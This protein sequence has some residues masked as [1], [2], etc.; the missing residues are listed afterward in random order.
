MEL[1]KPLPQSLTNMYILVRDMMKQN[2]IV[3][4]FQTGEFY[5]ALANIECWC[6]VTVLPRKRAVINLSVSIVKKNTNRTTGEILV[7]LL[8]YIS[9][10][11]SQKLSS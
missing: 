9:R 3:M 2:N 1:H 7:Q 10:I 5:V 4:K 11:W 8:T 6:M